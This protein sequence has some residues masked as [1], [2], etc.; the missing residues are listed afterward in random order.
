MRTYFKTITR[1]V[2]GNF[3]KFFAITIIMLLGIAFIGGLATITPRVKS[4]LSDQMNDLHYADVIIK[5]ESPFGFTPDQI[6][7]L[8]QIEYVEKVETRTAMDV[9]DGEVMTRIHV[10]D[11]FETELNKLTIE[12]RTPK[13]ANE[14]M[15]ERQNDETI[16]Y[17]IGDKVTVFGVEYEVVGIVS[18]PLIY[19]R[20]GEPS[21]IDTSVPL[22]NIVYFSKEFYPMP[23]PVTDLV[24]QIEGLG[25][26]EYFSDEYYDEVC[27]YTDRLE[28]DFGEEFVFLTI[29]DGK[30]YAV[31]DIYCEKVDVIILVFPAF[32]ILV[33]ALVVMTTMSR[34]IEEERPQVACLKSLGVSDA[35]VIFKYLFLSATC[36][37]LALLIG[38]PL[39]MFILPSVIYPIFEFVFFLAPSNGA[40]YF[41][42]G[43]ISFG[44]ITTVVLAVTFIVSKNRLKEKPAEL[45]I[46]KAP[47][48]GKKI[49]FERI[50]FIW[51]RLS[52]KYKS[53]I[54]NIFRYKKHL[55]MTVLSVAGSTALVFAGFGLLDIAEVL[56]GGSFAGLEQTVKPISLVVV[57][58]GLLLSIFVIYNLTNLNVGERKKEIATLSVL[59]YRDGEVLGYIYRE[60]IMMSFVGDVIGIGLG[61]LLVDRVLK[62]LEFGT[63]SDVCWYSYLIT[64]GVVLAFVF[65]TNLILRK[66]ILSIDMSTSLKAND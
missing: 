12:G 65:I 62:Y 28:K 31:L 24:L 59:G 42:T 3:A 25:Q 58:F 18:N 19:D 33:A 34:M 13:S 57:I 10:Y 1:S 36:C 7:K 21:V 11:N 20:M 27:S 38:L 16:N 4:S 2:K 30:S 14:I 47:K 61:Y 50:G 49:L 63:G 9:L 32:F 46:G 64:F 52:F 43:L 66:K 48:A 55:I 60:I 15:V 8:E 37:V 56:K 22:K 39:G 6:L 40:L 44:L 35:R 23:L 26:R 54:R 5:T 29:R 41:S 53:S 45:M 17:K 51:K